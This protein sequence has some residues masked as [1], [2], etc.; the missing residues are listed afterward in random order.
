MQR[1][2]HRGSFEMGNGQTPIVFIVDGDVFVRESL[3]ALTRC[4]GWHPVGFASAREFLAH[5]RAHVPSCLVLDVTLPDLDGLDLQNCIA[6]DRFKLPIIFISGKCDVPTTVKAMKA[7]AQEFLTK[8]FDDE[9]LL[10][11]IRNA[12]EQSLAA[13]RRESEIQALRSRYASLTI[14]ES[15]VMVLIVAGLL[16]RQA[17]GE[18][19]ISESTVKA[20]RGKVMEK[21]KASSLPD[22]VKMAARLGLPSPLRKYSSTTPYLCIDWRGNLLD[23]SV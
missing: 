20:H 13:L 21:M 6:A 23:G 11:A 14:R 18:L 7:G 8:P 22:L 4:A 3:E 16:N 19:G 17:G 9:A 10:N 1:F 5:P 2:D 12:I 15:Q